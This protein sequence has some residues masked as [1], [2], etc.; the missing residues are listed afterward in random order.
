MTSLADDLLNDL[1]SLDGGSDIDDDLD[2]MVAGPSGSTSAS[3][4]VVAADG[5]PGV[6]QEEDVEG[7][8]EDDE[9]ADGELGEDVKPGEVHV[10][11]GGVRP[12]E[13][14]DQEAVE[15][16]DL[17]AVKEVGKV[18]KLYGG[19]TLKEVLS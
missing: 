7:E 6:K 18:A 15:A 3:A 17:G 13:E 4:T 1:D 10:P 16:M 9:M 5:S 14:L 11:E 12:A 19:R 8:G 2:N